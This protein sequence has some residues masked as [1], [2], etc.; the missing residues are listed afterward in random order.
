MAVSFFGGQTPTTT[1]QRGYKR[2]KGLIMLQRSVGIAWLLGALPVAVVL[3][4]SDPQDIR[5]HT[6]YDALLV[7]LNL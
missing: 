6:C 1:V 5:L 4:S 3:G 2:I 7:A